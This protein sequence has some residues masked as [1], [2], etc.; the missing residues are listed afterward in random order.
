MLE[1]CLA[2]IRQRI[3]GLGERNRL[4]SESIRFLATTVLGEETRFTRRHE[5]CAITSPTG[6]R[7]SA[8]LAHGAASAV[9]PRSLSVCASS[10]A[11]DESAASS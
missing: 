8:S 4:A 7:S 10:A 6:A 11:R 1:E 9:E 2:L 5:N 3:G